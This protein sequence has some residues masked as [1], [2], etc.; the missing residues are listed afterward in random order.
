MCVRVY[1]CVCVGRC[2]CS[3]EHNNV[4][5]AIIGNKFRSFQLPSDPNTTQQR[6]VHN[7]QV[8]WDPCYTNVEISLTTCSSVA[9]DVTDIGVFVCAEL[10]QD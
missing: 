9:C 1:M 6:P 7:F 10:S 5:Y 8:V 3:L 2:V 4:F